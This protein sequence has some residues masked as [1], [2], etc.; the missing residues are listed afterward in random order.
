MIMI[1]VINLK[2]RKYLRI[3]SLKISAK[4]K[5]PKKAIKKTLGELRSYLIRRKGRAEIGCA[6]FFWR[7][8]VA[9]IAGEYLQRNET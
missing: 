2:R 7:Q 9:D 8:T 6:L 1:F 3:I 4:D 5:S